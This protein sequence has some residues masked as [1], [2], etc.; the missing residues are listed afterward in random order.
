[1]QLTAREIKNLAEYALGIEIKENG[2][3]VDDDELDDYDF[4][5]SSNVKVREDDGTVVVFRR[6]VTCDGCDGNECVPISERVT[7]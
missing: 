7:I 2:L 1:M 3:G 4:V 5:I 6:V